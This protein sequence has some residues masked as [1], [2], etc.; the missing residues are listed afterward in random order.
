[1]INTEDELLLSHCADLLRLCVDNC[2]LTYSRFLDMR[3]QSLVYGKFHREAGF[4]LFFFGGYDEAERAV[5]YARRW[6]LDR[7]PLFVDF[8]GQGGN[9][10]NFVSQCV[11][12][13]SCVMN[14]AVFC[15]RTWIRC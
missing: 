5:A 13:G 11:L 2:M 9:C 15:R 14:L 3:Q 6:A 8:T 4:R 12:A 10:T 7:N 1:M